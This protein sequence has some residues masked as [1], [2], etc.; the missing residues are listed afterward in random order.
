MKC[1]IYMAVVIP[2]FEGINYIF[3]FTPQIYIQISSAW[4]WGTN[5]NISKVNEAIRIVLYSLLANATATKLTDIYLPD[6]SDP[7]CQ[8][9]PEH[10]HCSGSWQHTLHGLNSQ[11]C[12]STHLP[13]CGAESSP[14]PTRPAL[15]P[16]Y[17]HVTRWGI[18]SGDR[19]KSHLIKSHDLTPCWSHDL[20]KDWS[21]D[22]GN[23]T[24]LHKFNRHQKYKILPVEADPLDPPSTNRNVY[25]YQDSP[26]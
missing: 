7:P 16:S 17:S 22:P 4:W 20:P 13:I 10:S 23:S 1:W 24:Q 19:G 2:P 3:N 5:R 21:H 15:K 8:H 9:S 11:P 12:R 14:S 6:C 18:Q 26:Y 25:T